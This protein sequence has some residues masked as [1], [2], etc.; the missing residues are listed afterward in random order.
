MAAPGQ[1]G[2]IA[3]F[4]WFGVRAFGL[5]A[6]RQGEKRGEGGGDELHSFSRLLTGMAV[7][8]GRVGNVNPLTRQCHRCGEPDHIGVS[9]PG[10]GHA[11]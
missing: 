7:G 2:A 6:R 5:G 1:S 4:G 10:S 11:Y 9:A 8:R 3:G